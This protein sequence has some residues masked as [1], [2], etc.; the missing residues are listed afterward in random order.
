LFD[1]AWKRLLSFPE[2][3]DHPGISDATLADL[4]GDG[5]LEM[6]VGYR[7]AVGVHCVK[8]DGERIWRNRAAEN[9]FR[10]DVTGPDRRGQRLLLVAQGLVLPIDAAGNERPP[11]VLSDAFL[12]L[13]FTADLEGDERSEWCA[14][15]LKWLG[16]GEPAGN[17]AVGLSPR[18]DELWRY[19]LPEGM[20]RH[21][22]F[23]MVAAGNLL[24]GEAGQWVIAAA[25]GSMHILGAGG[26]LIDRF[27]YGAAPSGMAIANLD[28]RPALLVATDEGLEAWQFEMLE[29][30]ETG[31]Q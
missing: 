28:G 13:I 11:I 18:G 27:N 31:R 2:F 5:E 14:I 3:G 22:A 29:Q 8:L 19:E 21:A 10:L 25:D 1:A 12:R 4:N 17:L 9:V 7:E 6:L 26:G 23:E 15:A 20:H 24:G 16:S 30:D